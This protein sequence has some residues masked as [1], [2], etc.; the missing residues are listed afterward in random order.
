MQTLKSL[1]EGAS[2]MSQLSLGQRPAH[3][4]DMESCL[5]EFAQLLTQEAWKT[6][7]S[8]IENFRAHG[9]D[10]RTLLKVMMLVSYVNFE[11]RVALGL[12]L[13]PETQNWNEFRSISRKSLVSLA[14][15]AGRPFDYL[16]SYGQS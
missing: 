5:F 15:P 6:T 3:L 12:G 8:H 13:H 16:F 4:S 9:L 11:N 2:A 7:E 1:G 10:D 14:L